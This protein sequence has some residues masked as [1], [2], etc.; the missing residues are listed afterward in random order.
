LHE[1][2]EE[3]DFMM[4][5]REALIS[6]SAAAIGTATPSS[7]ALIR[8]LDPAL[9]EAQ[10]ALPSTQ[11]NAAIDERL[12]K[13]VAELA[14]RPNSEE[15]VPVIL[16]CLNLVTDKQGKPARPAKLSPMNIAVVADFRRNAAA[17]ERIKPDSPGGDVA[18]LIQIMAERDVA[19]GGKE[20]K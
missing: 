17:W 14:A 2:Q 10:K 15:G 16:A 9:S 8:F 4:N 18:T 5:R 12:R 20:Y 7:S 1:S 3:E 13:D 11:S 6:L 19:N